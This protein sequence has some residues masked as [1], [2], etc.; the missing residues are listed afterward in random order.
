MYLYIGQSLIRAE[1]GW[2][3]VRGAVR[4]SSLLFEKGNVVCF[5]VF[6]SYFRKIYC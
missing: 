3:T 2:G 1:R 4:S 5:G 6:V